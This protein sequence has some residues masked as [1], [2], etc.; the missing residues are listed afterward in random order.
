VTIKFSKVISTFKSHLRRQLGPKTILWHVN[1][2][3][4]S[5]RIN[6][7]GD[8]MWS[9]RNPMTLPLEAARFQQEMG[10]ISSAPRQAMAPKTHKRCTQT[11]N[12]ARHFRRPLFVHQS[13][14]SKEEARRDGLGTK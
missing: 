1:N 9:F 12:R 13:S 11:S 3:R 8:N 7:S 10:D 4:K 6:S 5:S 2:D 14:G